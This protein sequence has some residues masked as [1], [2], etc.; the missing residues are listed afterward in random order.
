MTDH[1]HDQDVPKVP[2][3]LIGML[4]VVAL[5]LS[6]TVSLGFASREAVPAEARAAA[7][8]QALSQRSLYF[9]D[10]PDGAVRVEDAATSEQIALIDAGHGGFVRSTMRSLVHVR[11]QKGIGAETPFDL[12]LWDDGG[13]TLSDSAT[14]KAVEL[15]SFGPDNRAAF[16]ALLERE[17]A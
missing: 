14:G 13:L 1:H 6:A 10:E 15:G 4:L 16:A 9:H 2:L 12:T 17:T 7:G 3:M 5:V 8:T 11:R